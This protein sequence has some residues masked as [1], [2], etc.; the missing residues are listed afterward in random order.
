MCVHVHVC[1]CEC[2]WVCFLCTIST[3]PIRVCVCVIKSACVHVCMHAFVRTCVRACA[4]VYINIFSPLS[5]RKC[6]QQRIVYSIETFRNTN[7]I[8][9]ICVIFC[10]T[11]YTSDWLMLLLLLRKKE[12]SSFAGSSMCS[13]EVWMAHFAK[14]KIIIDR[15]YVYIYVY[16]YIYISIYIYIYI[17]FI[18][19]CIY[20]HI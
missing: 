3:I 7:Q 17:L 20:I 8:S 6:L 1:V 5:V 19:I 2:L 14:M 12:S 13:S 9:L 4:C 11:Q 16:M 18:H 15:M 10:S